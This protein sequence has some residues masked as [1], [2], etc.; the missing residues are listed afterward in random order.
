MDRAP[1][2]ELVQAPDQ[3]L[4]SQEIYSY[5]YDLS[6]RDF[7]GVRVRNFARKSFSVLVLILSA[8]GIFFTAFYFLILRNYIENLRSEN[9]LY[10]NSIEA[11][12]S[13]I[14]RLSPP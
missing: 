8:A 3:E 11:A 6:K 4:D 7:R 2:T 1:S 10:R 14:V 13:E 9:L 5:I 12:N